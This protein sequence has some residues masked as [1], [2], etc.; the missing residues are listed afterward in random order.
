MNF[1]Q[2]AGDIPSLQPPVL[3]HIGSW[4]ITSSLMLIWLILLLTIVV[5]RVLFKI[6]SLRPGIYQNIFEVLYESMLK[7]VDQITSSR[8]ISEKI[9]PLIATLFLFIGVSNLITLIPGL[10]SLTYNGKEIFRSPTTDFN[11]TFALALAMLILIQVQSIRD[12]GIFGYIGRFI[13]IKPLILSFKQGLGAGLTAFIN[14]LIGFLDIVSEIAKV[15]SLSMRLFGNIFAGEV[16]TVI[17]MAGLAYALPAVWMAMGILT[18]V[19]Q[20]LVFGSLVAA[21]YTISLNPGKQ[22]AGN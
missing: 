7:L 3:F 8:K 11:T 15:V 22:A 14:F 19:V 9:F 4:P 20:A 1:L 21:Y 12:W 17:I 2:V 5:V 13:Q 18:G 16:L 10:T 6:L